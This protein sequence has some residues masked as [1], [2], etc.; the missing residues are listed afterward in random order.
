LTEILTKHPDAINFL[1]HRPFQRQK[2]DFIFCDGQV[3]RMHVRAEYRETSEAS[4]L[5]TN[6]LVL[7]MQWIRQDGK[8]VMLLHKADAWDTVALFYT[9]SKFSSLQLFRP[10]KKHSIRS[11]FSPSPKEYSLRVQ[12][13]CVLWPLEG[14]MA[15]RCLWKQ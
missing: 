10:K 7:A 13:R 2:F 12:R 5:L 6:Q 9:F 14:G 11:S 4:R 8:M 15:Y 1:Q 3:L